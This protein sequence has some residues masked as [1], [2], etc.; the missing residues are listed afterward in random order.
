MTPLQV[1]KPI[2]HDLMAAI[3]FAAVFFVA[4][5][6]LHWEDLTSV[7]AAS[8][9]GIAIAVAQF[10]SKRISGAPV[11]PLQWLSAGVVVILG[12]MTIALHNGYFIKLKPTA[13]DLAAGLFMLTRDWMTPYM[14]EQERKYI[15]R[16][17]IMLAEKAW[18][19][20]M[21]VF[22]A[23]NVPV[24]FLFDSAVWVIYATFV[25]TTIVIVLFF[26]QYSMFKSLARRNAE[27]GQVATS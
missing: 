26:V 13:I 10:V 22:A 15:P 12:T 11:G 9:A 21:V 4:R 19:A 24:A 2:V 17:T 8:G 3:A 23:I 18:G 5:K 14:P 1:A 6:L 20:L 16:R 25:P 7:Y 27:A